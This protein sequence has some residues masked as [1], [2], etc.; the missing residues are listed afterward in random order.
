MWN[1]TKRIQ[2]GSSLNTNSIKK[3][4]KIPS[5]SDV[6]ESLLTV[7]IDPG[8]QR[9]GHE[10]LE[11]F[12]DLTIASVISHSDRSWSSRCTNIGIGTIDQQAR[13]SLSI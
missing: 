4:L 1:S 6:R 9:Y 12:R 2:L 5:V 11:S 3:M 13:I 10:Q 8:D 7:L